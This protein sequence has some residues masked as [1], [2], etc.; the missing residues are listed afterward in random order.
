MIKGKSVKM[1]WD[2]FS[3][4][5]FHF[6]SRDISELNLVDSFFKEVWRFLKCL[7]RRQLDYK[8][9][10]LEKCVHYY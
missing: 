6:A 7:N 4:N 9:V 5:L 2:F 3:S 1:K 10:V 8:D